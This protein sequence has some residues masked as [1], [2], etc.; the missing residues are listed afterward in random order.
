[1][2]ARTPEARVTQDIDLLAEGGDLPHAFD[3][4]RALAS[5]DLGDFVSFELVD[6]KPI[7]AED[8][9]RAGLKVTFVPMLG[10][11]RR[12]RVSVDL[13]VDRVPC[14]S[15]ETVTPADR[16]EVE[17]VPVFDYRMY[18]IANSMAFASSSNLR[19]WVI[20]RL[21]K[22]I[23]LSIPVRY[24]S[25]AASNARLSACSFCQK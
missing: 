13:V 8:E 9:Y 7:K 11:K 3:E 12:R 4:L 22:Y 2:L 19:K 15:P 1:M 23:G 16:I 17:G 18:P 14:G 25:S 24:R 5:L 6:A 10:G 20:R 21:L